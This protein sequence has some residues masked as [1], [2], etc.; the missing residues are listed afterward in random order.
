VFHLFTLHNRH[1]LTEAE[2]S[3]SLKRLLDPALMPYAFRTLYEREALPTPE[4]CRAALREIAAERLE[5]LR[6]EEGRMRREVDEPDR[7][8]AADRASILPDTGEA[9]LFFRY[10]SEARSTFH[11]AYREMVQALLTDKGIL[12]NQW[13]RNLLKRRLAEL[14]IAA[15][16]PRRD[17]SGAVGVGD[18]TVSPNEPKSDGAAGVEGVSAQDPGPTAP[19]PG[20]DAG[21]PATRAG[22]PSMSA[23]HSPTSS[24]SPNEPKPDAPPATATAGGAPSAVR[25]APER[26][27]A[28]EP[29][30]AVGSPRVVGEAR[31]A[32]L[33]CRDA[34][35]G[36]DACGCRVGITPGDVGRSRIVGGG[37]GTDRGAPGV[38][39]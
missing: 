29:V 18:T 26:V 6:I 16:V 30:A 36:D 37:T 22:V 17:G 39:G 5:G 33:D 13:A 14:D 31:D 19:A 12:G 35:A 24:V 7:A 8:E 4:Q 28:D 2:Y 25:E 3:A 20:P 9:R 38:R 21:T 27:A 32:C 1:L 15:D 34:E 11:R 23:S 10:H